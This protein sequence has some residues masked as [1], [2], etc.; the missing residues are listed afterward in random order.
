MRCA[1]ERVWVSL[2]LSASHRL[3][4]CCCA[5]VGERTSQ[6]WP[7]GSGKR[8]GIEMRGREVRKGHM[9]FIIMGCKWFN[10]CMSQYKHNELTCC[11]ESLG[12]NCSRWNETLH[13]RPALQK[14]CPSRLSQNVIPEER[15]AGSARRVTKNARQSRRNCRVRAAD[16]AHH[17]H[18]PES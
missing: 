13:G 4:H 9:T 6:R 11:L 1:C 5:H 15:G 14:V 17:H 8:L 12:C 3:H 16:A 10:M 7:A 2:R 18:L